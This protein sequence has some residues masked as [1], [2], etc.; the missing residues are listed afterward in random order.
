[1]GVHRNLDPGDFTDKPPPL[2][3]NFPS[4]PA[5]DPTELTAY[6]DAAYGN[7]PHKRRSMTG[8]AI[9]LAGGAVVF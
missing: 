6:T 1:M 4:V 9:C 3:D 8:F 2:P 5:Y 7:D